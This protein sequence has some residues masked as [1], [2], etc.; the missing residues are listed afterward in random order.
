MSSREGLLIRPEYRHDWSDS[1]TFDRGNQA[2]NWKNQDT[3]LVGF[4]AY[5]GPK[6]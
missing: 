1:R 2:A 6:R 4:V 3:L 5:F